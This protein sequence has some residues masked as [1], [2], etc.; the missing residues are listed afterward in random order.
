MSTSIEDRLRAYA[1]QLD[2]AAAGQEVSTR[3]PPHIAPPWRVAL[4]VGVAAAAIVAIVV[5]AQRDDRPRMTDAPSTTTVTTTSATDAATTTTVPEAVAPMPVGG[6]RDIASSPLTAREDA[7]AVWTGSEFLVWGG[8]NDNFMYQQGAA[9]DPATDT[10]RSIAD[11]QWAGIGS[12]SVWTGTQFVVIW[13]LSGAVYDV[14]TDTW[15]Q[16]ALAA[17]DPDEFGGFL[18]AAWIDGQ[19]LALT[20]HREPGTAVGRLAVVAIVPGDDSWRTLAVSDVEYGPQMLPVA[21]PTG[22]TVSQIAGD[23]TNAQVWTYHADSDLW[24]DRGPYTPPDGQLVESFLPV[25]TD[26]GWAAIASLWTEADGSQSA[27]VT[28]SGDTWITNALGE[29]ISVTQAV[30]VGGDRLVLFGPDEVDLVS[31]STGKIVDRWSADGFG[32]MFQA[33]AWNGTE[34]FAWGGRADGPVLA[35]G[36]IWTPNGPSPATTTTTPDVRCIDTTRS[37]PTTA[38]DWDDSASSATVPASEQ[39]ATPTD[40]SKALFEL[41]LRRLPEYTTGSHGDRSAS[42]GGCATTRR[43]AVTAAGTNS[44]VAVSI[45]RLTEPISI[46]ASIPHDVAFTRLAPDLFV[47]DSP[48]TGNRIVV[49]VLD[50]GTIIDVRASGQDALGFAGWPT[51][52]LT[53]DHPAPQP[54]EQ[55]IDDLIELANIA[56]DQ[57]ISTRQPTG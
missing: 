37:S 19:L 57:L 7:G 12:M 22:F 8:R 23:G 34:L 24:I 45:V 29:S 47:S 40:H 48:T 43:A 13:K 33:L 10:W 41:L 2:D 15:S 52:T 1:Q 38:A 14:A 49:K 3:E 42:A 18:A 51:T 31:V 46:E 44:S 32:R 30:S 50:D 36:K 53:A 54:P 55:T 21:T 39:P 26:S 6:W 5:V 4:A 16:D 9:Y 28:D 11:N 56:T 20:M 35:T 27:I 17:L 25:S